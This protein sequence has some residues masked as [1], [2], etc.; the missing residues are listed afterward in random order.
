MFSRSQT[1]STT[2][3]IWQMPPRFLIACASMDRQDS[4]EAGSA[5]APRRAVELDSDNH[6]M[7]STGVDSTGTL[8]APFMSAPE[9]VAGGCHH[10]GAGGF[11]TSEA[12]LPLLG[13]R[14]ALPFALP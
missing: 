11:L 10:P 14:H 1:T 8:G 2:P 13:V 12:L 7:P 9:P 6:P 5:T 3:T 4:R